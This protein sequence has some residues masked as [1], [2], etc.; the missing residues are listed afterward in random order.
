MVSLAGKVWVAFRM[1]LGHVWLR[2]GLRLWWRLL[3]V[4]T[5]CEDVVEQPGVSGVAVSTIRDV[6]CVLQ[7]SWRC[8]TFSH[9]RLTRSVCHIYIYIYITGLVSNSEVHADAILVFFKYYLASVMCRRRDDVCEGEI[10][11][12]YSVKYCTQ[13]STLQWDV[14]GVMLWRQQTWLPSAIR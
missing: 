11:G 10:S 2:G 12:E 8:L 14:L 4:G 9:R 6:L 13:F 1:C 7:T 5:V 3:C